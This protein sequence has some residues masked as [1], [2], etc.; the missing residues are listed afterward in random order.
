M[1][2]IMMGNGAGELYGARLY[3]LVLGIEWLGAQVC[4]LFGWST[5]IPTCTKRFETVGAV[6]VELLCGVE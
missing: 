3:L 2:G 5:M 6:F 4:L 1:K